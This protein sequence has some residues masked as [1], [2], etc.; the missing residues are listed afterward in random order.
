VPK[1]I[2][3]CICTSIQCIYAFV[4]GE[5]LTQYKIFAHTDYQKLEGT[6]VSTVCHCRDVLVGQW[7]R[8]KWPGSS[9]RWQ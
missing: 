1:L 6:L 2:Q 8:K 7:W 5:K 4:A 3:V 9:C